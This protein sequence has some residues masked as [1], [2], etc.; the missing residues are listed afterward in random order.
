[1]KPRVSIVIPAY[2]EGSD[3]ENVLS[4]LIEAVELPSEI[5]V[6]VDSPDDST[7]PYV[8]KYADRNPHIHCLV[9][10]VQPGPAQAIRFGIERATADVIVVTMADGCDDPE[11]IDHLVRLV[12]RGIR[13]EDSR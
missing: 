7:V 1:V 9:N 8:E 5:V 3:I 6:V 11:Q 10:D 4:R 12:E 13:V 2:N